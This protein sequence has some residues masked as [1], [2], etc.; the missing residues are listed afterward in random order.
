MDIFDNQKKDIAIIGL[1]E[2]GSRHLQ[3][4]IKCDF[5]S[6]IY[7]VDPS[8]KSIE[9]AKNRIDYSKSLPVYFYKSISD[10]PE[11][12]DLAII[13]TS[14]NIRFQVISDLM[15]IT[16]TK[17]LIL[18]KVLFQKIDE[19]DL[20]T[21]IIRSNK[22]SS[23]VNCPRRI[24]PFYHK[25]KNFLEGRENITFELKGGLWGL[26]CNSIH[27]IDLFEWITDSEL[28]SIDIRNLDPVIHQSKREGFIELSGNLKGDFTNHN[29]LFLVSD[30]NESGSTLSIVIK[31]EG[32]KIF[33]NEIEGKY[34]IQEDGIQANETFK[35]FRPP[36]QSELTH[37][38]AKEVI[39]E[40]K[41]GLTPYIESIKQHRILLDS[42]KLHI[43]K[44]INQEIEYCAIT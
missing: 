10:L 16:K 1:G 11:R 2:I 26:A 5:P 4:L 21:T 30:S 31:G 36:F 8:D 42:F 28:L 40:N 33:I 32:F 37:L 9:I 39:F 23:W 20:A 3:G 41:S 15:D 38:I 14:S 25:V 12:L 6:N 27:F 29:K 24:W 7:C 35:S 18:E 13:A 34:S 44:T 43:E 17:S 19:L 22:V